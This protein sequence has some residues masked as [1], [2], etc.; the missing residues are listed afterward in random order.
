M[1]FNEDIVI[2]GAGIAGLSTSLALHRYVFYE[3]KYIVLLRAILIIVFDFFSFFSCNNF[4]VRYSEFGSGIIRWFESY[5]IR[6]YHV[7]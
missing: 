7:D 3:K 1:E 6:A 4:Q 5:R 2:V